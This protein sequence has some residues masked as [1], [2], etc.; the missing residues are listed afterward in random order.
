VAKNRRLVA[1][2]V[3][4]LVI[5]VAA[6]VAYGVFKDDPKPA[7]WR[8]DPVATLSPESEEIPILVMEA[9]CTSG[10]LATGRIVA[11]VTYTT[12]SI[13]IDIKVN[14]LGAGNYECQGVD[15]PYLVV[16]N[17][18]LGDRELVDPHAPTP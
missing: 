16:L 18:P 14:P 3:G 2:V 11:K 12:E 1:L 13:I 10:R 7:T 5:A 15:T 9:D 6:W 8:V 4:A 17:E